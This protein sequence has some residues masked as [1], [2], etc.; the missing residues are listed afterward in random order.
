MSGSAANDGLLAHVAEQLEALGD[1]SS[2]AMFGGYALYRHGLIFGIVHDDTL[3]FRTDEASRAAFEE[4]GSVPFSPRGGQTLHAYWEVP[5][6][7]LED[8]EVLGA[9]ARRACLTH[10]GPG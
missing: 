1:V 5:A 9:W 2:R 3:Y 10:E 4:A 7:V 8:P 6:E